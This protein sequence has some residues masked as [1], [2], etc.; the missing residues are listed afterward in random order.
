LLYTQTI[1]MAVK[2][3]VTAV[4]QHVI[5]DVKQIENKETNELVG[6]WLSEPRV[7]VYNRNEDNNVNIGFANYCLVSD[8]SEF[9]LKADHVVAILEPRADVASKYAEVAFPTPETPENDESSADNS[10]DGSDTSSSD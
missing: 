1:Q 2:V 3:L 10:A 9:S 6:Y 7:V 8:E 4:G 5:A